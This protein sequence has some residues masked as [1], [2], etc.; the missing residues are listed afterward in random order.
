MADDDNLRIIEEEDYPE[1]TN[2]TVDQTE[3]PPP[4]PR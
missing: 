3:G 2:P 1:L 4:P